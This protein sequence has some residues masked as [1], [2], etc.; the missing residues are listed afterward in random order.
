MYVWVMYASLHVVCIC[1]YSMQ[2]I[3]YIGMVHLTVTHVV[4]HFQRKKKFVVFHYHAFKCHFY[5]VLNFKK[6]FF[7]D[8][9]SI[10]QSLKI[11]KFLP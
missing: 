8:I 2:Q 3:T 4:G 10:T 5:Q 7:T 9:A 6:T 11:T 1:M